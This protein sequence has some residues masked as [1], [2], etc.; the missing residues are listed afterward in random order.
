VLRW[1]PDQFWRATPRELIAAAG[2]ARPA[3]RPD[4]EGMMAAYPDGA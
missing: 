1:N 2:L 3:G 4:L